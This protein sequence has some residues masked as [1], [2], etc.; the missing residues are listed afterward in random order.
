MTNAKKL[1]K[2]A[3]KEQERQ[4]LIREL[5]RYFPK[6]STV[7]TILRSVSR[8]GMRR[9]IAVLSIPDGDTRISWLSYD[10]AR[11]LDYKI[12]TKRSDGLIISGAGE[13]KGFR[14]AYDLSSV[15]WNDGY[16][17]NHRWL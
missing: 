7:Y 5:R 2:A 10:V 15:I 16:A 11:L 9:V 12:S 8:S 4:G 17:L 3:L 13:D 14:I 6:G 1:T